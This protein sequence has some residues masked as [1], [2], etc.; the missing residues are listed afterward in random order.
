MSKEK[1]SCATPGILWYFSVAHEYFGN[2]HVT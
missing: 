2:R 1:Y